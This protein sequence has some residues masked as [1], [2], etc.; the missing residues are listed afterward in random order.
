MTKQEIIDHITELNDCYDIS[1]DGLSELNKGTECPYLQT[2]NCLA[3]LP[4]KTA[5]PHANI[6]VE[7]G[8][9]EQEIRRMERALAGVRH[10]RDCMKRFEQ[11]FK[12]GKERK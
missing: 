12:Q 4:R 7:K 10:K 6:W 2:N 5:S 9:L 8:M 11:K 3:S 1:C